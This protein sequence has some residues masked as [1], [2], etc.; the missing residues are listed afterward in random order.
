[1][2]YHTSFR[3]YNGAVFGFPD[4]HL[5][6]Q[7]GPL[8]VGIGIVLETIVP[9][10]AVGFFGSQFFQPYL[11]V[12]VQAGFIVI[13]KNGCTDVHGIYQVILVLLF[14]V[15]YNVLHETSIHSSYMVL[16]T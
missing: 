8:Q 13:D 4:H 9:V 12:V 3:C 15:W 16:S 14:L 1:M 5:T 6:S 2:E 10:L 7:N 11:E